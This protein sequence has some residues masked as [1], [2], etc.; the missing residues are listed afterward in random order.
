MFAN[1]LR[2]PDHGQ[3][4]AAALGVPDDAALMAL[5]VGLG[6]PYAEVLVMAA[7]LLDARIE[8]DEVVDDLKQALLAAELA[9]FPEQRVVA[10]SRVGVGFFPA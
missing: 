1:P 6:L 10:R 9:Q 4:L 7:G 3:A 5:H 2:Q 8:D